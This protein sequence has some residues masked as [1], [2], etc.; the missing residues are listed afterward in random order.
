MLFIGNT[1]DPVASLGNA[2]KMSRYYPG[3][4]VLTVDTIGVGHLFL[5]SHGQVGPKLIHIFFPAH[6]A[7]VFKH[8][9]QPR[10]AVLHS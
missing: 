1:A 10:H 7:G 5:M 2:K 9:H 8:V 4:V 6:F 3:S